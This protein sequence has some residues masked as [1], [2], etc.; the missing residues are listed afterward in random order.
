MELVEVVGGRVHAELLEEPLEKPAAG[1]RKDTDL[2]VP[3]LF[4]TLEEPLEKPAAAQRI[5][6][7]CRDCDCQL[8][9]PTFAAT[10]IVNSSLPPSL[11]PSV[12]L[13]VCLGLSAIVII[14][15]TALKKKGGGAGAKAEERRRGKFED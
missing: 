9:P 2:R 6:H 13:S 15:I 7:H 4:I 1:P 10:A 11:P 3:Y 12:F 14:I 8:L 5:H